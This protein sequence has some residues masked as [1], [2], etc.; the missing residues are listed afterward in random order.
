MRLRFA[1]AIG[2]DLEQVELLIAAA[3]VQAT[4]V[5][6]SSTQASMEAVEAQAKAVLGEA[7]D[8]ETMLQTAGVSGVLVVSRPHVTQDIAD[9]GS[10]GGSAGGVV[11]GV[12]A[13]VLGGIL[14]L[15]LGLWLGSRSRSADPIRKPVLG[16]E[17]SVNNS[18]PASTPPTKR[19][20]NKPPAG[21]NEMVSKG[22][23]E[24]VTAI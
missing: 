23:P 16:M 5:T 7:T 1:A 24:Y 9:E 22:Q 4:F 11:I 13:G 6:Y 19:P 8:V 12:V 2:V 10:A 17:H 15:G 3:S 21:S 20:S 18:R 14:L